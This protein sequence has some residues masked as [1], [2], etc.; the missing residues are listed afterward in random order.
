MDE[1]EHHVEVQRE[2]SSAGLLLFLFLLVVGVISG[3][4][5]WPAIHLTSTPP[6]PTSLPEQSG[7]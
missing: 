1:E 4:V 2:A 3:I 5:F 7:R 6:S